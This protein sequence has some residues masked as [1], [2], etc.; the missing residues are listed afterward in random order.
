MQD[1][2]GGK[3]IF[4]I[5]YINIAKVYEISMMIDNVQITS[6]V[7]EKSQS[8]ETNRSSNAGISIDYLSQIK[9]NIGANK[10]DKSSSANKIIESIEIK[11]TKSILLRKIIDKSKNPTSFENLNEGDLIKLE[12]V[13]LQLHNEIELRQVKMLT[14]GALKG[15]SYEG[16]EINNLINSTLKDYSYVLIGK[17]ANEQLI[18]KVPMQF[19]N[20]FENLYNIDDLLMGSI[21]LIGIYKKKIKKSN[22]RNTFS[23]IQELGQSTSN[24]RIES[25]RENVEQELQEP[26]FDDDK[27]YN[28]VD[29]I[30]IVQDIYK[31]EPFEVAKQNWFQS[32]KKWL[33]ALFKKGK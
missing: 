14:N 30:A 26:V 28:F 8:K 9:A 20:E 17:F 16:I 29:T 4:N 7:N 1:N 32:L 12:N 10:E 33:S 6:I 25:S 22:I 19:E 31:E 15:F 5:Y 23:T 27:L 21:T 2:K 3:M 18:I 13:Q 24:S 11:T